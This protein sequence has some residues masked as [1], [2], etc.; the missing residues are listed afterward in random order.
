MPAAPRPSRFLL[1]QAGAALAV[2]ALVASLAGGVRAQEDDAVTA[3]ELREQ[4]EERDAVII[5][6][7]RRVDSLER[8][9]EGETVD[10]TPEIPEEE[11]PSLAEPAPEEEPE[12]RGTGGLEVD[13][14]AA[15][16][17]LERTL[18]EEGVLLLP[19][20]QAELSPS[21][22]F[23]R[24]DSRVPGVSGGQV[25][26]SETER[27]RFRF[28]LDA[29]L[30]LP[31]D[32]QV[33]LSL[34]YVLVNQ[35][36]NILVG[37][38]T[39]QSEGATEG[40]IDDIV[41]GVAKTLLRENGGWGPNLLARVTYDSATGQRQEDGIGLGGGFHEVRGQFVASKRLDPLVVVGSTAFTHAFETNDVQP[42]QQFDF[43]L[44][45]N[46]AVS[47]EASLSLTL[48]QSYNADLEVDGDN[49]DGSDRVSSSLSVGASTIVAPRT[50]LR[51]VGSVGLTDDATDYSFRV[52]L[53]FR[54]DTPIF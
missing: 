6:L 49:V 7:L 29:S 51:V 15:E 54:F 43:S 44:G 25:A 5:E 11:R 4:L 41:V 52:S 18:V 31:L 48:N 50:L 37:G 32:S 16:R 3:E 34:P 40:T 19:A 23:A 21:F 24:T 46:L 35:Q 33:E 26:E 13:E 14:L 36:S 30:G 53:P 2:T 42:G 8:R 27:N 9:L 22:D 10:V 17:A 20:G 28:A 12:E 1:R 39:Q 38:G 47:P 45:V